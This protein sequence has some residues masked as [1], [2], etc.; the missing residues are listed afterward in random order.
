MTLA[1]APARTP[2][3]ASPLPRGAGCRTV[4]PSLAPRVARSREDASGAAPAPIL[5]A[6]RLDARS[7]CRLDGDPPV[8]VGDEA[9][10]YGS[11]SSNTSPLLRSSTLAAPAS[12]RSPPRG[13]RRVMRHTARADGCAVTPAAAPHSMLACASRHGCGLGGSPR[14]RFRGGGLAQL[15]ATRPVAALTPAS[16][17]RPAPRRRWRPDR[18]DSRRRRP[19]PRR[20]CRSR[21]PAL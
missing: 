20:G 17:C 7:G 4:G 13:R 16:D 21:S 14:H 6:S 8:G 19:A 9:S 12:P 3:R 15:G 1:E 10:S 18:P 11:L 2:G 5:G